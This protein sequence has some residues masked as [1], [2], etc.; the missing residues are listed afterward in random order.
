MKKFTLDSIKFTTN[1]ATITAIVSLLA[2]ATTMYVQNKNLQ[3]SAKA[4]I[5]SNEALVTKVNT[6]DSTLL[7]MNQWMKF[8]DETIKELAKYPPSR[9]EADMRNMEYNITREIRLRHGLEP[10]NRVEFDASKDVDVGT[11]NGN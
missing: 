11:P 7:I 9:I 6:I 3:A 10:P 1:W 5:H 8:R 2:W 4:L